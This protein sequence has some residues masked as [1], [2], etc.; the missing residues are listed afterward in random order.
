MKAAEPAEA[1]GRSEI[2]ANSGSAI[3]GISFVTQGQLKDDDILAPMG[4]NFQTIGPH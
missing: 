1:A 3:S 4:K 2:S